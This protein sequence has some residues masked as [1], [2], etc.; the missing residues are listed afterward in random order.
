[1]PEWITYI[2]NYSECL[3]VELVSVTF[4]DGS[5]FR[6]SCFEYGTKHRFKKWYTV[7]IRLHLAGQCKY[8]SNEQMVYYTD[9]INTV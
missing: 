1:M 7:M 5:S 9:I 3:E 6:K 4:S 8:I 2:E